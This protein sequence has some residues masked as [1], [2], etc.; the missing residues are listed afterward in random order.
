[1]SDELRKVFSTH[2]SLLITHHSFEREAPEHAALAL[3][4]VVADGGEVP[5]D[6]M[7]PTG[8]GEKFLKVGR[9]AWDESPLGYLS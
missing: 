8:R 3:V 2:H 9:G 5:K 6:R 7:L 1:M 4:V